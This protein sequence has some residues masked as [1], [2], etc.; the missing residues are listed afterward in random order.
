MVSSL[1]KGGTSFGTE[2]G[3]A[4]GTPQYMSPEQ[5]SGQSHTADART[6]IYGLGAILY[7]MLTLR[8]PVEGAN[9]QEILDNVV[10][11][12]IAPPAEAVRAQPPAHLPHGKPPSALAAIAMKALAPEP[13]DRHAS[14]R[15]LQAVLRAARAKL[16]L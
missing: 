5:A 9:V 3:L 7:A 16:K 1:R 2:E 12:R 14:V 8:P 6:D 10:A 11:G 4:L 15:E 13:G